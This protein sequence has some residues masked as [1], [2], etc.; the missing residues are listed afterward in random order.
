[1]LRKILIALALL[2][3]ALTVGGVYL[4]HRI[5]SKLTR[6]NREKLEKLEPRVIT[7]AGQFKKSTFYKGEDLG[8]VREILVGWPANREGAALTVVGNRGAH[9]LDNSGLLKKRVRFSKDIFCAV[10]VTEL[11]ASG[12]YGFLTRDESWATAVILFDKQG[13]E[14]WSYAG[15]LL[16]GVDDS[17]GGRLDAKGN[18]Q[19]VIGF[20][21]EDGIALVDNEG[22]KIWQKTDANVWHVETLDINGDGQKEILH[23]NARGQLLVRNARGEIVAH[24]LTDHYVS[25]F[26][27]T[28]WGAESQARHILIPSQEP[29]DGCCKPVIL[30]LDAEGK[31]VIHF[32]APLG[33]LMHRTQGTPVRFPKDVSYYAVLQANGPLK[34]SMLFLYDAAGKISYQ[35]ILGDACFGIASMPEKAGDRLLVGC[36]GNILEYSTITAGYHHAGEE[37]HPVSR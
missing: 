8:E 4:F 23:S 26:G 37:R 6:D 31:T 2:M 7:G 17:V 32:D 16:K 20:N 21:G 35:E 33:D 29:G 12:G 19:V 34:R 1:M 36:S 10:E 22:R 24:Y 14:R 11:D 18:L 25:H 3:L 28:R 30:V 5:D 9:F 13:Q 27:L 15:G